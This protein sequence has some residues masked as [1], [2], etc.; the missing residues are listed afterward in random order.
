MSKVVIVGGGQ[1]GTSMLKTFMGLDS[2]ELAGICDVDGQAPGMLLARQKGIPAFTDLLQ[3]LALPRIDVIIEATGSRKVKEII[4]ENQPAESS[5][6]DAQAANIIM[7]MVE[8]R[9]VLMT[10]VLKEAH[11]IADIGALLDQTIHTVRRSI[12]EVAHSAE[13]M[14]NRSIQLGQAADE[15]QHHLGETGEVLEF[16]KSVAQQTKMLGLNA[17]IEAARAGE[18]GRGF[19]VVAEEV[20]K[21]A[22]DSSASV[23]Q[24]APVLNNIELS[25]TDITS[26]VKATGEINQKQAA[27]TEEVAASIQELEDMSAKLAVTAKNLA[28]II[29]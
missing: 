25:I 6:V 24:I 18:H 15:A 22:D 12:D 21:L 8:S 14:A 20:R 4:V 2:I 13:Q 19:A 28:T 1:G 5:L 10:Q 3:L 9:E 29:E 7:T 17:A 16:I 26:E 11:V 23:A 27:L